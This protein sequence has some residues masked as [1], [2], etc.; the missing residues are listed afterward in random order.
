[1]LG[2]VDRYLRV[3]EEF[4]LIEQG[5]PEDERKRIEQGMPEDERKRVRKVALGL[6]FNIES[7][8]IINT[9]Y[10]SP[11]LDFIISR[12][13]HMPHDEPIEL[14]PGYMHYIGLNFQRFKREP[15][16]RPCRNNVFEVE[17]FDANLATKYPVH[18]S[19]TLCHRILSQNLYIKHC[20][21]YSPFLPYPVIP[22]HPDFDDSPVL[23]FN[24]S[25]FKIE[26]L[27]Q[28]AKCMFNLLQK[29]QDPVTYMNIPEAQEC[30]YLGSVP[31]CED[32]EHQLIQTRRTPLW[33]LWSEKYNDARL[34][35]LK[36]AFQLVFEVDIVQNRLGKSFH[37]NNDSEP[38]LRYLREN[39]ALVTI[40]RKVEK[41]EL[42]REDLEYPLAE[43]L[44][45]IG[46]LMGLWIGISVIGLFEVL[47]LLGLMSVT[48]VEWL[49]AQM[50]SKPPIR[51]NRNAADGRY[52]TNSHCAQWA[53]REETVQKHLS[54]ELDTIKLADTGD[55]NRSDLGM[56]QSHRILFD[57]VTDQQAHLECPN[58]CDSQQHQKSPVKKEA[59]QVTKPLMLPSQCHYFK[60]D[61][62]SEE[63]DCKSIHAE[64]L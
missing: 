64:A 37:M 57:G 20:G 3:G 54:T 59:L 62:N 17:V 21:C 18:G 45:D 47:E 32:I 23:C 61:E 50:R 25:R 28:N 49:T 12:P 43:L 4:T 2:C 11:T 36:A 16:K 5:M 48:V 39:F 1:M 29:Y 8:M 6:K 14:L 10:V 38:A 27:N 19:A 24:M 56:K 40:E 31:P 44:S 63:L 51:Q 35:F 52:A 33:E 7:H 46:G 53:C 34:S 55:L 22:S 26:Q 30:E 42:I 60:S 9:S 41:G 58:I 13:G 15:S